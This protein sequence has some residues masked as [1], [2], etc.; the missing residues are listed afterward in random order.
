MCYSPTGCDYRKVSRTQEYLF[1]P[2]CGVGDFSG[3]LHGA[4]AAKVYFG[5]LNLMNRSPQMFSDCSYNHWKLW[6]KVHG[7]VS[8]AMAFWDKANIRMERPEAL[9]SAFRVATFQT[10]PGDPESPRICQIGNLFQLLFALLHQ[11]W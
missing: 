3:S 4:F 1:S 7:D 8:M 11:K 6:F 2:R 9:A 5:Q 10:W